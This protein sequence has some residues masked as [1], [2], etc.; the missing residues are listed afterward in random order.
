MKPTTI[1]I[2]STKHLKQILIP[3][4]KIKTLVDEKTTTLIQKSINIFKK[5]DEIN[6]EILNKIDD[7][8]EISEGV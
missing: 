5:R 4:Q 7:I 8:D 6:K 2:D 1:Q 3:V